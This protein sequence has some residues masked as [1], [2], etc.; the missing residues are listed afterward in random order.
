MNRLYIS[1]FMKNI[2]QL[3]T[4]GLESATGQVGELSLL[5]RINLEVGNLRAPRCAAG[6]FHIAYPTP[7]LFL[8]VPISEINKSIYEYNRKG[9]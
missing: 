8:Y 7:I 2:L 1:F 4:D 5:T 3:T 9:K 6:G